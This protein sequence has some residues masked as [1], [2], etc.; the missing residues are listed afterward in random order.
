MSTLDKEKKPV[1]DAEKKTLKEKADKV[2]TEL[3]NGAD[4]EELAKRNLLNTA[5]IS[6]IITILLI[7]DIK[8]SK[9][10]K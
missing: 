8:T 5:P 4:F 1:N 3:E 7:E 6:N 10:Y 9:A 2:F